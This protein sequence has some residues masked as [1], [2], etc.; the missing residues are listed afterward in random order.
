MRVSPRETPEPRTETTFDPEH[1]QDPSTPRG[2]DCGRVFKALERDTTRPGSWLQA[3]CF[4]T[5]QA[6]RLLPVLQLMRLRQG[7]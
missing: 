6:L 5:M 4:K 3:S 2:N 7:E 1:N